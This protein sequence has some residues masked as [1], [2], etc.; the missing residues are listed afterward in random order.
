MQPSVGD[1]GQ[2]Y[3]RLPA[4]FIVCKLAYDNISLYNQY[5]NAQPFSDAVLCGRVS[6]FCRISVDLK[7]EA[8]MSILHHINIV[9]L[10]AIIF[11]LG[12]YG[13]VIEYVLHGALNDFIFIYDVCNLYSHKH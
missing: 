1:D 9:A 5:I 13:I 10:F 2:R 12:H 11:E 4:V 6:F 7:K 3:Q 8:R